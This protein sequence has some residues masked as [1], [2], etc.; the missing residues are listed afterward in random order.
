MVA[1][2]IIFIFLPSRPDI[3]VSA[4]LAVSWGDGAGEMLGRPFGRHNYSVAGN[5]RSLE[6]SIAV[7]VFSFIAFYT[8]VVLFSTINPIQ[9]LPILFLISIV[10]MFVEAISPMWSDNFLIPIFTAGLLYFLIPI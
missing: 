1:Y 9:V 3:F 5:E 8:S 10:V 7:L 6:G 4:I 2:G